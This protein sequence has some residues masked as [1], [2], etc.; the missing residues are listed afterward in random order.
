MGLVRG[1]ATVL[2]PEKF[3]VECL[4]DIGSAYLSSGLLFVK[5]SDEKTISFI[6]LS[7]LIE[8]EMKSCSVLYL[9]LVV[10]GAWKENGLYLCD[11]V[12]YLW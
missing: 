11:R 7:M 4:I 3:Q 8:L 12:P 10:Y 2:C 9:H 1:R 6:S 5:E